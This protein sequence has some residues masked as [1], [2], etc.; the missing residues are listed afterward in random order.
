MTDPET[1]TALRAELAA[2]H[3]QIDRAEQRLIQAQAGLCPSAAFCRSEIERLERALAA[4]TQNIGQPFS[5]DGQGLSNRHEQGA[6]N[7]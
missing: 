1:I 6:N 2:C 5:E 4:S 7:V 3:V